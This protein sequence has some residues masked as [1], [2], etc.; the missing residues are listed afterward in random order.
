MKQTHL[1]Y[2]CCVEDSE[3]NAAALPSY[4]GQ[5]TI[6]LHAD[7]FRILNTSDNPEEAFEV[8][9]YLVDSLDLLVVYG[10]MPAIPEY[11]PAFFAALD[12]KYPQGVNWDIA[13]KGLNY[14][15]IPSHEE[16]LPNNTVAVDRADQL[17]NLLETESGLDVDA[18]ID[19]LLADLD[20][21]YNSQGE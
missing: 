17:W 12:E 21:I 19:S 1:W 11:Q 8:L 2:T 14:P 9:T 15:D 4:D 10:G 20:V 13:I 3:W 16:W 5:V 6:R 18:E 7:T